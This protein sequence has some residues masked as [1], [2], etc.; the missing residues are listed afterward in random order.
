M[1]ETES[2]GLAGQSGVNSASR[3]QLWRAAWH[4]LFGYDFFISYAWADG[5]PYAEALERALTQ[6]SPKYRCFLDQKQMGG[7]EAW[8]ASVRRALRKSSVLVLVASPKALSSD[9]VYDEL[10]TFS[11]RHRPLIPIDFGNAVSGLAKTH[12]LHPVLEERLRLEQSEDS[13][14][15]GSGQ[16]SP[17]VVAFLH[18]SFGFVPIARRRRLILLLTV[19]LFAALAGIAVIRYWAEQ[20]ARRRAEAETRRAQTKESLLLANLSREETARGNAVNAM[21]LAIRGLPS[22]FDPPDRPLV[23]E[24]TG[25]LASAMEVQREVTVLR[26]EQELAGFIIFSRD[27]A[28]VLAGSRKGEAY[29]W[30]ARTGERRVT[31]RGHGGAVSAAEFSPDGRRVVTAS[32]DGTA[33]IWDAATGVQQSVLFHGKPVTDAAFRDDGTQVVT[34]SAEDGTARLWDAT[35]GKELLL[36]PHEQ[37]FS[38]VLA[39]KE[40]REVSDLLAFAALW[41]TPA[42]GAFYF[43]GRLQN[44]LASGFPVLAV[45]PDGR[46]VV[47]NDPGG[48]SFLWDSLTS[49]QLLQL[50]GHTTGVNSAAFSPDGKR[51]VTTSYDGTARI[52][53]ATTGQSLAVLQGHEDIANSATFDLSASRV[54]TVSADNSA[55]VWDAQTGAPL[56]VLRGHTAGVVGASFSPDGTRVVTAANDGTARIWDVSQR[57]YALRGHTTLVNSS[58]FSSDDSRIV[59]A[60]ED[61]TVRL[62]DAKTRVELRQLLKGASQVMTASFSPDDA[63][64]VTVSFQKGIQVLDAV[65]G[66]SLVTIPSPEGNFNSAVFSP[67]DGKL[68]ATASTDGTARL[69]DSQTGK[70]VAMLHASSESVAAVGFSRDGKRLITAGDDHIARVWEVVSRKEL[71]TLKVHSRVFSA[72]LSPAEKSDLSVTAS[73]DGSAIL[74]NVATRTEVFRLIIPGETIDF[75]SFSRDGSRIVTTSRNK[76]RLWDTNTGRELMVLRLSEAEYANSAAFSHDD[77]QVIT[78]SSNGTVKIWQVFRSPEELVGTA[79]DRL[80]RQLSPEEEGNYFLTAAAT[81]PCDRKRT[82]S[83]NR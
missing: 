83:S 27:G 59:T 22:A 73:E 42:A 40:E 37:L 11:R 51:L 19:A 46:R 23:G 48:P 65:T 38:A 77:Q 36:V 2:K 39:A 7:G 1:L 24:T 49:K 44:G 28:T 60:S 17:E 20:D 8:R 75:A 78:N 12:R 74:W 81:D 69:W 34:T 82:R 54:V 4:R 52:W 71:H 3:V 31:L 64:V 43:T 50:G 18:Q 10:S 79:C 26:G 21:L 47:S 66:K 68:L 14:R 57:G 16:P 62:W 35:T 32:A 72:A 56:M 55:R 41:N 6:L 29:L 63:R 80:P 67:I 5:R 9:N 70:Q 61:G 45:S 25:A 15:L 58:D 13:Q 30:D 53:N 33:R 76:I